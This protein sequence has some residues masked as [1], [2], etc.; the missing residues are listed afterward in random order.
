M[1]MKQ[2]LPPMGWN[3]YCTVNCDPTEDLILEHAEILVSS[4]LRDCG[5][6]YVNIDDGW[7][8]KE[9]DVNGRIVARSDRFPHGMKYLT[10]RLHSMGL[11][12]GIYL[13]CGLT[14]WHGDAGSLGHE[15]EDAR[16]V[17][18]MGF[19]YLKY[20]RHP[21][22]DD[23]VRDTVEE[24]VK[25]GMAVKNCG[26]EMVYNLCEHGTTNPWLWAY[27]VGQLWRTG[28]DVRDVWDGDCGIM[29]IVDKI[30][31]PIFSSAGVSHYN[32][33]D[34]LV[35]G[36]HCQNDW[37][38]AG[39]SDIEYRSI[40]SLWCMMSAPLLIGLDL[41]RMDETAKTIL[42][43][44]YL[45]SIDQDS[46]CMQGRVVRREESKFDIWVKPLSGVRWAVGLLNRTSEAE[47]LSFSAEDMGLTNNI[48]GNL[49]DVWTG[50]VLRFDGGFSAE[51]HGHEM[52][53]YIFEPIF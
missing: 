35:V 42:T 6:I 40:F 16:T 18:E 12:A 27:G 10:D 52:K 51:T 45:I 7:A 50:E 37:M 31:G 19:D 11:K 39:C 14:T 44:K 33:P 2:P 3:S 25:M 47:T 8:E 28:F 30:N 38:G 53:V 17:A 48:K 13:G 4:G 41:R 43:N 20:D 49:L 9:R 15:F 24:Y 26:R 1:Y 29:T 34:M 22:G 21:C 36:M 32:D 23:P 5:Y 46:L